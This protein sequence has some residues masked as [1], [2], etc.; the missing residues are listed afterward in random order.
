MVLNKTKIEISGKSQTVFSKKSL[1]KSSVIFTLS[2]PK[3]EKLT[4]SKP[5]SNLF[6]NFAIEN[7]QKLHQ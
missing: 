1:V 6:T 7:Q 3:K 5:R 4:F 2:I